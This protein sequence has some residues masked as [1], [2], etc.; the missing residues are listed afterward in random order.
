MLELSIKSNA[1][2]RTSMNDLQTDQENERETRTVPGDQEV[3]R[4]ASIEEVNKQ[5]QEGIKDL[6]SN[7]SNKKASV[8][9]EAN[10]NV[11]DQSAIAVDT[12]VNKLPPFK[13]GLLFPDPP[14]LSTGMTQ[15]G[16]EA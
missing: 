2:S 13:V 14:A 1:F 10:G 5:W 11:G 9:F 7:R 8:Q 16:T 15:K 12:E 6:E 4:R 3:K